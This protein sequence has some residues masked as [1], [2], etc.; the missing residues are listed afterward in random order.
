MVTSRTSGMHFPLFHPLLRPQQSPTPGETSHKATPK[1]ATLLS[2]EAAKEIAALSQQH[3][4]VFGSFRRNPVTATYCTL[5]AA[6]ATIQADRL[7]HTASRNPTTHLICT[8]STGGTFGVLG[9]CQMLL[10][11][12]SSNG[13]WPGADRS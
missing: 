10:E 11:Q 4:T 3:R 6:L 2:E 7:G 9:P 8:F 13:L 12:C 5:S 1:E